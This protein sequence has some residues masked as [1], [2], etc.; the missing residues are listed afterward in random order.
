VDVR[1]FASLF[2]DLQESKKQEL[3]IFAEDVYC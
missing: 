1:R 3:E 2:G